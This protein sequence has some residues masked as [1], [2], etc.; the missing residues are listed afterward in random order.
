MAYAVKTIYYTLQGEGAQTGRPAV[1]LRFAGCNLWSGHE[2]DRKAATCPFC[3]TEFVGT[4]GPGG[5]KF[6]SAT[7][8]AAAVAAAWPDAPAGPVRRDRPLVVC[9]GGEPLLQLDDQAVSALHEAGF[10]VA[11]ETNGTREPPGHLDWLCVSPKAG[12]RLEVLK[13]HE[14]KLV[15]PQPGAPPEDFEGLD[16]ERFYLQPM[17]GPRREQNTQLAVEYCLAHPQWRLSLQTHKY[18]GID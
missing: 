3:D 14:L 11:V 10:E 4:D 13:G 2:K 6:G 18:I 15:Y 7:D 9:T 16:F 1:F 5:G 8:L 12:A 17:D